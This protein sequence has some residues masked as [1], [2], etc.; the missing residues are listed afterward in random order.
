MP[1]KAEGRNGSGLTIS[2][3]S[4]RRGSGGLG[5]GK[6]RLGYAPYLATVLPPQAEGSLKNV[7]WSVSFSC[8][9]LSNG[10]PYFLEQN[11]EPITVLKA[12]QPHPMLCSHS[13]SPSNLTRCFFFC[14]YSVLPFSVNRKRYTFLGDEL[15]K[16]FRSFSLV[17]F[18]SA[19]PRPPS[20]AVLPLIRHAQN[21]QDLDIWEEW[22]EP[23]L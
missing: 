19:R 8:S 3:E 4:N 20:L 1:W 18:Y 17:S 13:S 7:I 12:S 2:K 21:R 9:K 16:G 6:G 23:G 5:E 22:K 10:F 15:E 14:S 11:S